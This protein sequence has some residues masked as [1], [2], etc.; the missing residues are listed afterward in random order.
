[1]LNS[2]EGILGLTS[3][4]FS[5]VEK[6]IEFLK[7]DNVFDGAMSKIRTLAEYDHDDGSFTREVVVDIAPNPLS[8]NLL[9]RLGVE[10]VEEILKD[11]KEAEKLVKAEDKKR[12]IKIEARRE[13]EKVER[14]AMYG[15]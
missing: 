14:E 3:L 11:L 7:E 4:D 10:E 1:M 2:F 8:H 13:A 12:E 15:V 9:A 5:T 6:Q